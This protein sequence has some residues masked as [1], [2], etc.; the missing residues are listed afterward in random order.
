MEKWNKAKT[1]M[2]SLRILILCITL[3]YLRKKL[4]IDIGG[5]ALVCL[6]AI[7]WGIST[8]FDDC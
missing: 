3:S 5:Y 8:A 6:T 4:G 7:M 2:H 1:V